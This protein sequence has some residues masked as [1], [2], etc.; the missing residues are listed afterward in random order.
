MSYLIRIGHGQSE[1]FA[2]LVINPGKGE[3]SHSISDVLDGKAHNLPA[4]AKVLPRLAR[5]VAEGG[6]MPQRP[7]TEERLPSLYSPFMRL[8][9]Q[10]GK[11][12]PDAPIDFV[13]GSPREAVERGAAC[14]DLLLQQL[15]ARRC[16]SMKSSP[17]PAQRLTRP[18]SA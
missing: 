1:A 9:F 17:P 12:T 13:P 4:G 6:V 18:G 3:K 11:P 14:A 16:A 5:P 2:R 8:A 15:K 10:R 7:A